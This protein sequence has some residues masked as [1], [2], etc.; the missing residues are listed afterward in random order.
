MRIGFDVSQ[1]GK[2]KAGCGYFADSLMQ[3]L[4]HV[5]PEYEYLLYASFGPYYWDAQAPN[6]VFL[7]LGE[8]VRLHLKHP[9]FDSAEFFW[10]HPSTEFWDEPLGMPDLIHANNFFVPYPLRQT[11]LVYTLY[12]L[13]FLHHPEWHTTANWVTTFLG[14]VYYASLFA[15]G[16]VAISEYSRQDFL[17]MFPYFPA[18]RIWVIPLASRFPISGV[19]PQP[20]KSAALRPGRFWLAVGTLEPRKNYPTLLR[21][22]AALLQ[23]V[24]DADPLVIAGGQG[25]RME[26][27]QALIASLGLQQRVHLLGYVSDAELQWLYAHCKAFVYPSLFEGFGLPVLEAMSLGAAVITSRATSLPEVA[28]EAALLVDPHQAEELR[29]AM[30]Q[31]HRNPAL[32]EDLKSR[33]FAQ[34]ARFSWEKT[35][36]QVL[37]VY[38]RVLSW[39]KRRIADTV[40]VPTAGGGAEV[41]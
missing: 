21:A 11:R 4:Y 17:R 28:G 24:P 41:G 9:D 14:G 1:T 16:I 25:W 26:Y 7:R 10:R 8:R 32:R 31:L 38:E 2:D 34:A 39:P 5:A 6:P 3:A 18:E 12:D 20:P 22:Y 30:L 13:S 33:A 40:P 36:R 15:D 27:L 37:A 29:D 19:A 23:E 35:A